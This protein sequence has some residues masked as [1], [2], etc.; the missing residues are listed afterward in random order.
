MKIFFDE[1]GYTGEDL[2]NKDQPW[3][4]LASTILT[5][6]EALALIR[7]IFKRV[8]ASE[9]KHNRLRKTL[10]GQARI[11]EL[12]RALKQ[13]PG[14]FGTSIAH[15]KY[16]LV[17][18]LVDW[19]VEPYLHDDGFDLY[20]KGAN[21][22][23]CNLIYIILRN[24]GGL[25]LFDSTLRD[26]QKM[27]RD[28]TPDAYNSFWRVINLHFNSASQKALQ[29]ILLWLVCG[30]KKLGY[31]HLLKIPEGAMDIG[32]PTAAGSVNFWRKKFSDAFEVIHDESSSMAKL[33]WL[34]DQLTNTRIE[35]ATVGYDS[36]LWSFPLGVTSTEFRRSNDFVQLQLADVIAGCTAEWCYSKSSKIKSSYT[37]LLD[38]AGVADLVFHGIYPTSDVTPDEL[39]T[40][41]P[42][43]GSIL[44]FVSS[45][46]EIPHRLR[47]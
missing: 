42:D 1:S 14:K 15:K 8:K 13:H 12:V 27:M 45:Q 10:S 2:S 17:S 16:V 39:G 46:L 26:F 25:S 23:M 41:S 11:A 7:D 20:E 36:R 47:G 9:L 35:P 18:M 31:N 44:D 40:N 4:V 19:W 33:K 38:E 21:I 37:D 5:D 43:R 30:E 22:G 6:Q 28:R 24:V 29:D 34:W 3:F 32:L